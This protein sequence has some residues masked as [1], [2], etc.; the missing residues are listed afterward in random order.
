MH[1]G[2]VQPL[3]DLIKPGS[4]NSFQEQSASHCLRKI[5]QALIRDYKDRGLVS[6]PLADTI[7]NVAI[8]SL[9]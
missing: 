5:V 1:V 9:T 7:T 2:F 3:L 8:V 4:G 6:T